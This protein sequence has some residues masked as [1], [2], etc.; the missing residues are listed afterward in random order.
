[1]LVSS[2]RDRCSDE[3]EIFETPESQTLEWPSQRLVLCRRV[4]TLSTVQSEFL[5][6]D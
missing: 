3:T 4:N 5:E 2:P 6:V 1:M